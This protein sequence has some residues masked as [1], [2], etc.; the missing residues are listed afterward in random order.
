MVLKLLHEI[1]DIDQKNTIFNLKI[2]EDEKKDLIELRDLVY[3]VFN[4]TPDDIRRRNLKKNP[5]SSRI[6]MKKI[7]KFF[8]QF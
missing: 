8:F 1:K 4:P 6:C 3:G 5:T 2:S 7:K